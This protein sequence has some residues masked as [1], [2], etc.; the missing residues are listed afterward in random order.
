MI[1]I[2]KCKVG[3]LYHITARN[4][5]CGV[6]TAGITH[7]TG[8]KHPSFVIAREKFGEIFLFEEW[9]WELGPPYGTAKPI[10]ELEEAPYYLPWIAGEICGGIVEQLMLNYLK[11]AEQRF[12]IEAKRIARYS[13]NLKNPEKLVQD[14]SST[15][16]I[17]KKVMQIIDGEPI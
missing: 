11:E 12:E 17:A 16:E 10:E 3:H 6:F 8:P 9:H 13:K 7:P 14:W 4:A 1:P 5:D 2:S 15:P